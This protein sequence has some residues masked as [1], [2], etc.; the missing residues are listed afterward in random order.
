ML[1]LVLW[2][3]KVASNWIHSLCL[4]RIK[5]GLWHFSR[6]PSRCLAICSSCEK[7]LA[8][9]LL[10]KRED[11]PCTCKSAFRHGWKKSKAKPAPSHVELLS[12]GRWLRGGLNLPGHLPLLYGKDAATSFALLCFAASGIGGVFSCCRMG[13]GHFSARNILPHEGTT[14]LAMCKGIPEHNCLWRRTLNWELG[15]S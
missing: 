7:I 3:G 13:C 8:C 10:G 15:T 6:K 12:S 11:Q 2:R 9:H 1:L 14:G 5:G 4:K